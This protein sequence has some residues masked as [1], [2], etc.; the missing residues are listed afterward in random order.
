MN[1]SSVSNTVRTFP[2]NSIKSN[3]NPEKNLSFKGIYLED[4]TVKQFL[5]N[6]KSVRLSMNVN[7][8]RRKIN[9]IR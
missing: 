7:I 2:K 5:Q 3:N 9:D 6:V 4:I 1:I 8:I